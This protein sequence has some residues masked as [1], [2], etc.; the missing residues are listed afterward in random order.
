MELLELSTGDVS[1]EFKPREA[2][3]LL[4]R[5]EEFGRV[6]SSPHAVHDLLKVGKIEL[7]Y[8]HEWDE[9]CLI[10]TSPAGSALLRELAAKPVRRKAA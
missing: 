6:R 8:Y 2:K 10:S 1:L 5:L 3:P 7:I 4:R 9:P